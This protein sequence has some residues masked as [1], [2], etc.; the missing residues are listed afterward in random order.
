MTSHQKSRP[1]HKPRPTAP[2]SPAL[3]KAVLSDPAQTG[4]PTGS[5]FDRL[6]RYVIYEES[7]NHL[8]YKENPL[9]TEEVRSIQKNCKENPEWVK[10]LADL[11]HEYHRLLEALGQSS[12][13]RISEPVPVRPAAPQRRFQLFPQF[14]L[15]QYRI[16]RLAT[17][18]AVTLI[19]GFGLLAGMSSLVTPRFFEATTITPATFTMRGESSVLGSG[20]NALHQKDYPTALALFQRTIN[21]N[22]HSDE[23]LLASYLSGSIHLTTARRTLL[24]F[25]LSFERVQV[26]SGITDFTYVLKNVQDTEKFQSLKEQC[27]FMLGQAWLMKKNI[28]NARQEFERV[29]QLHGIKKQ[30]SIKILSLLP[31]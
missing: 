7:P 14:S 12:F 5:D 6:M 15:P 16:P 26:D 28:L 10:V 17:V 21:E 22:P 27:H 11:H 24:G 25:F 20:I 1:K 19:V 3:F 23:A 29:I 13:S 30:E 2:F 8:A 18:F 31:L 9:T 4:K